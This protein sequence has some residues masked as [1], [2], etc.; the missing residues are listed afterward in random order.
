VS[1]TG[2]SSEDAEVYR[3]PRVGGILV[4]SVVE[5]GPA[6]KAGLQVEDVLLSVNGVPV[7]D[8]GDLQEQVAELGPDVRAEFE[9]YREGRRELVSVRLGEV[10]FAAQRKSAKAPTENG[11][12]ALL[13]MTI[14]DLT[15]QI[16]SDLGVRRT[17]GA[18]VTQV[19]PWSSAMQK[20]IVP[21]MMIKEVG[22]TPIRSAR[23]FRQAL[24]GL[25]GGQVVSMKLETPDGT[26]RIVNL[27]AEIQ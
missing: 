7:Q 4:Q 24:S 2:V 19:T 25:K 22:H 6:D 1:V 13:G 3:L 14:A 21:G 10:P 18:V 16:A 26:T 12:E 15:P 11:S 27:R 5:D 9:L 8:S 17:G 23:D 20:G